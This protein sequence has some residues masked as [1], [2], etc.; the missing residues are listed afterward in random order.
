MGPV[1][2]VEFENNDL[3]FIKDALKYTVKASGGHGSGTA[4]WQQYRSLHHAGCQ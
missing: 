1:V 3:P 2:D 4:Y